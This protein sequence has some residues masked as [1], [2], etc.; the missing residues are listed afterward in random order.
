[1]IID[2][3][4]TKTDSAKPLQ[5]LDVGTGDGL[6]LKATKKRLGDKV[7][8]HGI[9]AHVLMDSENTMDGIDYRVVDAERL[10][11]FYPAQRS[12][13]LI[14]SNLTMKHLIDPFGAIAQMYEALKPN[15][16]L[17]VDGFEQ[18]SINDNLPM[19]IDHLS[20]Q[21]YAVVADYIYELEGDGIKPVKISTLLIRK[22]HDHLELP[23]EYAGLTDYGKAN[24]KLKGI[25]FPKSSFPLTEKFKSIRGKMV[26]LYPDEFLRETYENILFSDVFLGIKVFKMHNLGSYTA[27]T[28]GNFE[29]MCRNKKPMNEEELKLTEEIRGLIPDVVSE[30][31]ERYRNED[32]FVEE[33]KGKLNF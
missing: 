8:V 29:G 1:M 19:F 21:G 15:G 17:V 14:V 27:N 7:E 12:F 18:D 26:G 20:Q 31:V 30:F 23:I 16:I 13:D 11:E 28:I 4:L 6:F 10:L 2:S 33:M 24:Y 9:T 5:I 22:T 32:R 25:D 3:L